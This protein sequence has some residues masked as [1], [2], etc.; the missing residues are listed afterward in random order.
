MDKRPRGAIRAAFLF[1]QYLR[2]MLMLFPRM[3]FSHNS[4]TNVSPNC[5]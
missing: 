5:F 3:F 1:A 4:Q 2:S